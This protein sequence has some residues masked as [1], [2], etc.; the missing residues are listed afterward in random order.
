MHALYEKLETIGF[1]NY[2][3]CTNYLS[4]PTVPYVFTDGR[5]NCATCENSVHI[6]YTQGVASSVNYIIYMMCTDAMMHTQV[7]T[8]DY[9][10]KTARVN[11]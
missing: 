7:R 2:Y 5:L 8:T 4:F 3:S 6:F 11:R 1:S 10:L 9:C